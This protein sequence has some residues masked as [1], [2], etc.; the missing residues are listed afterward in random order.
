MMN[1]IKEEC[2]KVYTENGDTAYSTTCNANL[3]FFGLAGAMRYNQSKMLALF[4][5]AYSE[6]PALAIKNLFYLRDIKYGM[7]ERQSFRT[8]FH[9]LCQTNP[10]VATQMLPYI[11]DYGRYDDLLKALDTPVQGDMITLLQNQLQKDLKA[12]E[13]KHPVSLLAK[14]LP[15]CNASNKITRKQGRQMAK[16][17]K[18]TEQ[19]YRK[20]LSLLRKDLHIL[21]NDLRQKDYSFPYSGVPA[22]AMHKYNQA[23]FRNDEE[24]F[25]AYLKDLQQ[26]KATVHADTLYP[27]Q[28]VHPF[29]RGALSKAQKDLMQAQWNTLSKTTFVS[30]TK[31]IV[32]RDGSGSM[33]GGFGSILPIEIATSLS[34][35][36]AGQLTGPFH[37]SFITF[38]SR[39]QLVCLQSEA[40]IEQ[41]QETKLY[42]DIS[43]TNLAAVYDLLLS[44]VDRPDFK[45][46][47]M[48]DRIVII[49][50]MEFDYGVREV[51]T[52]ET[53]RD[54]FAQKGLKLPEI[55]YWNVQARNIHFAASIR[56]A[57]IRFVSGS[58]QHTID[59][60]LQGDPV[61]SAEELMYK[62]LK[63]Y[64]FV[65][66]FF[67]DKEK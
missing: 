10:K 16:S 32:V 54:K 11:P 34:I 4:N 45:P 21:E 6:D 30:K 13:L 46:E 63:P 5:Q 44:V 66:S 52:Y 20:M 57:N 59:L 2:S 53:F 49:S 14:W 26:K 18:M 22:G 39:P 56:D 50:D 64:D 40:L 36:F 31:T 29:Y 25:E 1:L 41:L 62:A 58:S 61:Y 28:I 33:Y 48:V 42:N 67:L 9:D 19:E 24:R 15:S 27:Y 37:N 8:C 55:V 65:D 60:I 51:P 23:F 3:D 47:D 7:G 38:S 35:L 17:L 43:N 12:H